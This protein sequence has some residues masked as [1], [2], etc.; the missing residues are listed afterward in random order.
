MHVVRVGAR[1][2]VL[3]VVVL[4]REH[5][6]VVL[7]AD[8]GRLDALLAKVVAQRVAVLVLNV[9]VLERAEL[10]DGARQVALELVV[11]GRRKRRKL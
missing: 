5:L 1:R 3:V 7:P 6:P 9:Q 8:R 2:D 11:K 4:V 10:L